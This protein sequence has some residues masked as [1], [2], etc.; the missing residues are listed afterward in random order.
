MVIIRTTTKDFLYNE[1]FNVNIFKQKDIESF[2]LPLKSHLLFE[3]LYKNRDDMDK[4][5]EM[6]MGFFPY[7]GDPY[8]FEDEIVFNTS[9]IIFIGKIK[10]GSALYTNF[11]SSMTKKG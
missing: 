7:S 4:V 8:S 2:N 5:K 3:I 11:V 6:K 10:E 9:N 1:N